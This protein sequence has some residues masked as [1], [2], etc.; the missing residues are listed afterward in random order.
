MCLNC[1]GRNISA[2]SVDTNQNAIM[3]KAYWLESAPVMST[4]GQKG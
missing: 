3:G 4:P 2:D 1:L